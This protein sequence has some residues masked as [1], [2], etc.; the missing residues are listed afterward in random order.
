MHMEPIALQQIT[1]ITDGHSNQGISPIIA[2]KEALQNNIAVNVIGVV[3]EGEIG[4]EGEKEVKGI[5]DAGGGISQTVPVIQIAK[6]VQYVTRQAINKT[7][8]QVIHGEL[9]QIIGK[10]D[11]NSLHPKERVKIVEMM[12]RISEYSQLKILLLIDSS[13]SMNPKMER[14]EE[15]L[16]DFQISLS[17]RKGSA[18][19]AIATFPGEYRD[20]NVIMPWTSDLLKLNKISQSIIPSGNTPTGPAII[21]SIDYFIL[22]SFVNNG[23]GKLDEYII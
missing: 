6:T 19:I 10:E 4:L 1:L 12:D 14:I 21:K 20:I 11:I 13:A 17:S 23:T 3:D 8:Q 7:L 22:D 18:K 2:A 9:K 16:Y 5:A 15:A